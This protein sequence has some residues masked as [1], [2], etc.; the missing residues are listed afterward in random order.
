[1]RVTYG[2]RAE[3]DRFLAALDEVLKLPALPPAARAARNSCEMS[4]H[5]TPA[6]IDTAPCGG[7]RR[8]YA[9]WRFS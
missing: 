5:A 6:S 9:Y 3:N 2:T 1:M 4:S 8:A 7:R